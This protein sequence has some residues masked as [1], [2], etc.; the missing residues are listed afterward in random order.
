MVHRR[1]PT[2]AWLLVTVSTMAVPAASAS[3]LTLAWDPSAGATGYTVL[4]G[5]SPTSLTAQ[6]D[7]GAATQ[8]T[9]TNLSANSYY[10]F[11]VQARSSG[12]TSD[13][14]NMVCTLVDPPP[15]LPPV[16]DFNRDSQYDLVWQHQTLGNV[17]AWLM[18]GTTLTSGVMFDPAVVADLNWKL[19][20]R[21]DMNGDGATDLVWEHRVTGSVATWL[22]NG[23]KMVSSA[24]I[25]SV[26]PN[27][28]IVGVADANGD[29]NSDLFWHHKTTG[30]LALW[31][32]N[33]TTMTN[34]ILLGPTQVADLN[35]Q[36]AAVA[37]MDGDGHPDLVWQHQPTGGVAIWLMGGTQLSNAVAVG[38]EPDLNWQIKSAGDVDGDGRADLIWQNNGTGQIRAWLMNGTTLKSSVPFNP[39]KNADTNWKIVR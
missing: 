25:A 39:S 28:Q 11:A 2:I 23:T 7:A 30:M 12:G 5:T 33:G 15:S 14:S 4:Y 29:G 16:S 22:M 18:K 37:D 10:C 8:F 32:M 19:V 17:A 36:V 38:T 21:G 26:D 27:W 35:W 31:L 20:G 24:P 1:T 9:I 34:S 13:P 3:T 6:V